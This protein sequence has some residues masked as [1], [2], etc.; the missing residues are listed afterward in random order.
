MSNMWEIGIVL[1]GVGFLFFSVYLGLMFKSIGE[2]VKGVNKIIDRNSRD[3]EDIVM[4]TAEILTSVNSITTA[5]SG[6]S[7]AGIFSSV[8][9]EAVT[10]AQKRRNRKHRR[11]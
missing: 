2:T 6:I 5:V 4:S 9:K 1:I 8:A 7:K 11:G 10:I 3:I